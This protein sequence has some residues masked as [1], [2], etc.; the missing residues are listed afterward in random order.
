M[1]RES[2]RKVSERGEDF[3]LKFIDVIWSFRKK[4][5]IFYGVVCGFLIMFFDNDFGCGL[6]RFYLRFFFF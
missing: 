5:W 1:G 2:S 4:D 3:I 6:S